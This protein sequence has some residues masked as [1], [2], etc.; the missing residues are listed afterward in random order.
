MFSFWSKDDEEDSDC[1]DENDSEKVKSKHPV[2]LCSYQGIDLPDFLL[3]LNTVAVKP[4]RFLYVGNDKKDE[5]VRDKSP[6]PLT[7]NAV[8]QN[9]RNTNDFNERKRRMDGKH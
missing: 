1:N 8:I 3:L 9:N 2:T 5:H 6:N 7:S 4:E